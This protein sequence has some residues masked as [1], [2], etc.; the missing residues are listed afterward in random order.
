MSD[1]VTIASGDLAARIDPAGAQLTSLAYG[2]VEYLWQ[3]DPRWWN[4]HAPV[5][6]PIVGVLRNNEATSAQGPVKLARHGLARNYEHRI[7]EQRDD[8]VTFE[9]T[10]TAE[11]REVFPYAFKLNM[12]YTLTG[13]QTLKQAFRVENTGD[14]DLPF[15]VGGHPAFNVPVPGCDETWEDYELVFAEPWTYDSPT[16]AG[17]GLLTYDVVNPIVRD[18]DRMPLTREAFRFDTIML[19]NVPGNTVT[20]RG[21]TSGHGVR[22]DFEG[23]PYLGVWAGEGDAPFVALEPWTGHATLDTEDDVLEHKR[24][25]TI[26]APGEVFERA[27]TVT[28]L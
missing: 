9:L 24:N 1:I 7:V 3:A 2:G 28:V 16:I 8:T 22:V 21:R 4:R 15:S 18:A 20:L 27:F 5:L 10:D 26:L 11:T 14:V 23:F 12:S 6:F 17:P 19:E 13:P 25:I